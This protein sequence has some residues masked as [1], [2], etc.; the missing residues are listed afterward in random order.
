MKCDQKSPINLIIKMQEV[1]N[2][3]MIK[4]KDHCQKVRNINMIKNIKNLVKCLLEVEIWIKEMMSKITKK[5]NM[6]NIQE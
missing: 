4:I 5:S 2:L 6:N 1:V 3:I